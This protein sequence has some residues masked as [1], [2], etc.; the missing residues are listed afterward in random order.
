MISAPIVT[1]V[2]SLIGHYHS[3]NGGVSRTTRSGPTVWWAWPEEMERVGR[4][5]KTRDDYEHG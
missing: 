4:G 5:E 2:D 3:K 1:D